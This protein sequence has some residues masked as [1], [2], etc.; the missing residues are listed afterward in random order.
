MS[1]HV[2]KSISGFKLF[3]ISSFQGTLHVANCF[4]SGDVP[5]IKF[6][7]EVEVTTVLNHKPISYTEELQIN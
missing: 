4:H 6:P 2:Q 3:C 5:V 1:V 7:A